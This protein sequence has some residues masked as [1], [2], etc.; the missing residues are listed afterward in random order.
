MFVIQNG[1]I[2][3]DVS[4]C[5]GKNIIAFS[6]DYISRVVDIIFYYYYCIQRGIAYFSCKY[7]NM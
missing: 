3:Y 1:I 4:V 5:V 7:V 2:A 6:H